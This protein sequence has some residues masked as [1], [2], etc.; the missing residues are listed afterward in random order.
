LNTALNTVLNADKARSANRNSDRGAAIAK[1]IARQAIGS[2]PG[3]QRSSVSFFLL[4][5]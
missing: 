4:L 5:I 2:I 3:S 1:T